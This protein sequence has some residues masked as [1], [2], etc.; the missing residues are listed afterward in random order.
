LTVVVL[1]FNEESNLPAC[2]A[3]VAGWAESIV[4]VDSGS[5]DK[6]LEI[7]RHYGATVLT[8]PF[9]THAR[10]WR[11][12]LDHLSDVP[13][14]GGHE[15]VLGLDSDQRLTPELADEIAA[16]LRPD[17]APPSLEAIDGF[18][19]NRRH[20]FRGRWIRFGGCYPKYLL[21]LFRRQKV[22]FDDN[23]LVDHHFYV[24][25]QVQRFRHDLIEQNR[26]EED[27]SFWIQ[28]HVRYAR[29]LAEEQFRRMSGE[30]PLP[31]NLRPSLFGTPDQRVLWL[32]A[33]WFRLP[34]Y[35]RPILY[36]VYRFFFRL[37]I[38]DGKQG[39][40]FHFLHAL[41]FRLLVDI[42]LDQ[43]RQAKAGDQIPPAP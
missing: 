25:G 14:S 10:Q 20:I 28:K 8:N 3:S 15:W 27:I 33:R 7:A 41:W 26:K 4:V 43:L 17:S 38:L 29:S 32:K 36:F 37:G 19:L 35:V 12:A 11:W 13:S 40:E 9:D 39:F 16:W 42:N 1:T 23:D 34:L 6:T 22:F 5:T 21:K 30:A 31:G 24:P 2:L 18:Y